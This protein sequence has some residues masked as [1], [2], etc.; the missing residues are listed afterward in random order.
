MRTQGHSVRRVLSII[1]VMLYLTGAATVARSAGELVE[2]DQSLRPEQVVAIQLEALQHND[3]PHVDAGIEQ[4][5]MLAHPDNKR[6]TGP[7]PRFAGMLKSSS[8]R[9]MLNHHAHT[10]EV[11]ERSDTRVTFLIM[12]QAPSSDAIGY[13]WTVEK[14]AEG[15]LSGCWMTTAVSPPMP[16]G[17]VI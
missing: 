9:A 16:L 4:T 3:S 7:L 11:A 15:D 5:W 6:Y 12:I 17:E 1:G 10:I 8:F 2:P 13:E 14:V